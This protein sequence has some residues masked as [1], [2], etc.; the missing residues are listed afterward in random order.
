M[1]SGRPGK[2]SLK[3]A[4]LQS[5]VFPGNSVDCRRWWLIGVMLILC[6]CEKSS[7]I[8]GTHDERLRFHESTLDQWRAGPDWATRLA[9]QE[10]GTYS[11]SSEVDLERPENVLSWLLTQAAAGPVVLPS[12]GYYYWSA[13]VGGREVSGNIRFC[14]AKA[15]VLH[16][17]YFDRFDSNWQRGKT[18]RSQDG[19]AVSAIESDAELLVSVNYQGIERVFRVIQGRSLSGSPSIDTASGDEFICNLIDEAG[20]PLHL[21]WNRNR[22]TFFFRLNVAGKCNDKLFRVMTSGNYE[23]L[24][25][26]RSRYAFIRDGTGGELILVGV[27]DRHIHDNSYFDGPFDQVPPDLD[28]GDKLRSMYPLLKTLR[29]IDEHGN[30]VDVQG[31][32]VAISPYRRYSSVDNLVRIVRR[33]NLNTPR[34]WM[35]L[36]DP[37]V[38]DHEVGI[39]DGHSLSVSKHWP[40]TH[41]VSKSRDLDSTP[42]D[43]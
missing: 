43:R 17:G 26:Q 34:A 9:A 42:P 38:Q 25:A 15:G 11:V 4:P 13:V 8:P 20:W 2:L 22:L 32:R 35:D 29:P 27:L 5:F 24:V 19:V 36:S 18:F 37:R 1:L 10:I 33:L 23:L 30:Y 14:D 31:V 7:S 28:I 6:G 12:E 41:R 39:R 3:S 16:I 40:P 21:M